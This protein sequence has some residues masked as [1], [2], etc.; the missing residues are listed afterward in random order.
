MY[1]SSQIK[2]Q[3]KSQAGTAGVNAVNSTNKFKSLRTPLLIRA[4]AP[5]ASRIII[6]FSDDIIVLFIFVI[7]RGFLDLLVRRERTVMLAPW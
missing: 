3:I 7:L 1:S 2:S 6:F 5:C 4:A